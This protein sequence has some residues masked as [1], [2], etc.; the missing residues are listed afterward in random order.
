M[1]EKM[2]ALVT[3]ANKGLGKQV[4]KELVGHGYVVLVGS[5]D[6]SN[7]QAAAEEIGEGAVAIQLDVT[8][9]A[10]IASA[11]ER[12]TAEF[13]RLDLLVNN[14]AIVQSGRYATGEEVI[15]ASAASV[16]S[17]DEIRSVFETNALGAL[18]VTQA[19]LPLIRSSSAGRIVNVS[20]GVGSLTLNSDP[21]FPFRPYF[22]AT[23]TA[24]KTLLNAFT[25]ALAIELEGTGIKVRVAGPSYTATAIND[26]QG[27]DT[28]EVGARP[29]VLAALDTESP[30]GSFTGPDGAY[31]W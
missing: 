24:S 23:Y 6:S 31:P 13:G 3:G 15:A 29:L 25:L 14:A 11:A 28:V 1:Q 10:S 5:R 4:A 20:S 26:F 8:D 30:T 22:G 21:N 27:T 12:V 9:A 18:A 19:L 2:V 17:L 7:G 16:A